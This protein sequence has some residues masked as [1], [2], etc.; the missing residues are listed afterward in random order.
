[1]IQTEQSVLVDADID[2]AWHYAKNIPKWASIMPG[3]QECEIIDDDNSRWILKVGVGAMVRTVTVDVHVDE[4]AGPERVDF[5]VKLQGDP[6]E[7]GGSY[8]AAPA[9]PG[10]T[11]LTL[12]VHVK[13]SGPMAPM[14]EAMG[15]PVLSKFAKSFAEEL[16]DMIEASVVGGQPTRTKA[17]R[18]WFEQ[19]LDWLRRKFRFA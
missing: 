16:R 9:G 14:W 15:A 12:K 19:L 1:M 8:L 5:R 2:S 7:G 11:N 3:Y 6:V 10:K 4:W 18:S 17:R 13:G